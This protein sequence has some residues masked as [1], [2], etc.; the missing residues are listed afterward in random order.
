MANSPKMKIKKRV[1]KS[2]Y[3]SDSLSFKCGKAKD[4]KRILPFGWNK[5]GMVACTCNS[6][7][8]KRKDLKSKRKIKSH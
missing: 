6:E 7:T 1:S 3:S 2:I 5:I 8:G 4:K